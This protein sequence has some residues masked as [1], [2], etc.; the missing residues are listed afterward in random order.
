MKLFSHQRFY[1]VYSGVLTAALAILVFSGFTDD[2][3]SRAHWDEITVQRINVVEPDGTLRMIISNKAKAPGIYINGK[4]H[5]PGH[6]GDSAGMIFLN[7]EGTE[8]GGLSFSGAKD[9]SGNIRSIGHLSFDRYLQDQ[10]ITMTQAQQND[11]V[12]STFNVLDQPSWPISEYIDLVER[13]SS[14]PAD[15]QKAEVDKFLATHPLGAPRITLGRAPDRTASLDLKD[16]D[17]RVRATLKVGADGAA[18]LQFL[19][20]DGTVAAQYPQ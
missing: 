7:D 1:A 18:H 3:T 4:E 13:I 8:N 15:Q 9:A 5:L 17:G 16:G 10:M 14:L 19:N 20:A 11:D 12:S 2:Q 6:H